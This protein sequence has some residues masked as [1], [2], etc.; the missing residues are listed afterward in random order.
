MIPP[1]PNVA[2]LNQQIDFV[3]SKMVVH[4]RPAPFLRGDSPRHIGISSFGL[5]GTLAHIILEDQA[6]LTVEDQTPALKIFLLSAANQASFKSLLSRHAD[7]TVSAYAL[8]DDIDS[9]CRTS[10][11]GRDHFSI[12]RAWHV[13]DMSTLS[14]HLFNELEHPSPYQARKSLKLGLWFGLPASDKS[15][16][17]SSPV[18]NNLLPQIL[19]ESCNPE[20][21]FFSEQLLLANMLRLIGCDVSVVGG[22]GV[23]E[24]AAAIFAD[25]FP[26]D[27]VFSRRAGGAERNI[28]VVRGVK[29]SIFEYLT[30]FSPSRLVL[31]G[32]IGPTVFFIE[33]EYSS[34]RALIDLGGF[35]LLDEL[36][37]FDPDPIAAVASPASMT[38]VSSILGEVIDHDVLSTQSYWSN[39]AAPSYAI[40]GS[41][42]LKAM[43]ANCDV[44]VT[45]GGQAT[46]YETDA[47]GSGSIVHMAGKGLESALA[48]LYERGASI[49]WSKFGADGPRSHLPGYEIL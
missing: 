35:E 42:A 47:A 29:E 32:S 18:L 46:W 20:Y 40:D 31:R 48:Q 4:Q 22:E 12:R 16:S 10:Q 1:Q 28:S 19:S 49:D 2:R 30:Q 8:E 27:T 5:S 15:R 21:S 17:L 7:Y 38:Y 43:Q 45:L 14:M 11:L 13:Q 34:A 41:G 9:I 25:I 36:S 33:G 24:Y 44:I 39:V 37:F 23:A 6:D 3:G 26:L